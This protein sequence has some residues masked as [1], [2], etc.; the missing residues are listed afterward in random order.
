[1]YVQVMVMQNLHGQASGVADKL[2]LLS[3]PTHDWAGCIR[4]TVTERTQFKT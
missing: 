1:M 3:K 2:Q 4:V